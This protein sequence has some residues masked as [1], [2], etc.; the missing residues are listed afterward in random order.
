MPGL[1]CGLG[2]MSGMRPGH[3]SL[4]KNDPLRLNYSRRATT[5]ELG[6]SGAAQ[7][8]N[9]GRSTSDVI[10]SII[11][12]RLLHVFAEVASENCIP[13]HDGLVRV[14][15]IVRNV[16]DVWTYSVGD[17]VLSYTGQ[18]WVDYDADDVPLAYLACDLASFKSAAGLHCAAS[19]LANL[20]RSQQWKYDNADGAFL[21]WLRANDPQCVEDAHSYWNELR[22]PDF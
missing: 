9:V 13:P 19:K 10:I 22:S 3:R 17:I 2:E 12:H 15:N 5:G 4:V 1:P 8:H 18:L 11:E 6:N 16:P 14:G 20:P 7:P 21:D